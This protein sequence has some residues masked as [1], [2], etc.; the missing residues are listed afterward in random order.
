MSDKIVIGFHTFGNCTTGF[1]ISLANATRYEG[2]RLSNMI[3]VPSPYVTEARNKI[4]SQFLY[5][6]KGSHLMMVDADIQFR[7]DD[8]EKTYVA[9]KHVG[10]DIMF[11]CYALGDF[12]PS[13]FAPPAEGGHLPTVAEN[14][15]NGQVYDI[16]AGST[17]WLL[18]TRGAL[19]KVREANSGRHWPW[20]DHDIEVADSV[21]GGEL[22]KAENNTLRIGE[23]FTFSK[24]A[25]ECGIKLW[26]T[27]M[28]LLVHDKYQPL[29]PQFQAEAAKAEG[30]GLRYDVGAFAKIQGRD[31]ETKS[32]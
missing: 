28:P 27:T 2:S 7:E 18:A 11:G 17:G 12:R 21:T 23:D 20:F 31:G 16:Y 32:D 3:H 14:L 4:V 13:I 15:E 25:R 29:M 5:Q 22:Y 26:G 1:A 10:A 24:R 6:T 30:L 9:L 19:E 8:I